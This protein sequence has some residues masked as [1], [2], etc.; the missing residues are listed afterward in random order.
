L[1]NAEALEAACEAAG[2]GSEDRAGIAEV[3][4][5][6]FDHSAFTGRSGSF[7][8]YEG[9]GCVYWHMVSKLRLAIVEAW[10]RA[11][12]VGE[13][14]STLAAIA[15]HYEDVRA[16]LGCALE[17]RQYGAFPSDPYSHTPSH[18]G[19]RQPGMT[20]QVKED[21][22]ARRL[23]AGV[24]VHD[25]RLT[26]GVPLRLGA[27]RKDPYRGP[28][29]D[30]SDCEVPRGSVA[31]TVFGVPM[32]LTHGPALRV[33]A[34]LRDGTVVETETTSCDPELSQKL[35]ARTGEVTRLEV[36]LPSA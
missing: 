10:R 25:G 19:A 5:R 32:L 27:G 1:R 11:V 3:Y 22:V 18:A 17:P 8:G 2:L 13:D 31:I 33:R 21:L 35:F 12:A 14:A 20:G 6:V 29:G 36:T 28:L 26:I 34:F 16:G 7:F 24:H 4:E 30:A 15:R 23:E 9:L